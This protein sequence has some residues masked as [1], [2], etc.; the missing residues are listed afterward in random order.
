MAKQYVCDICKKGIP[1]H[2][3][4]I[5]ESSGLIKF[6]VPHAEPRNSYAGFKIELMSNE[7]EDICKSCVVKL[8]VE[9]LS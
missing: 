8:M 1:E 4:C 7:V 9:V 3:K 5:I 2:E 6:R